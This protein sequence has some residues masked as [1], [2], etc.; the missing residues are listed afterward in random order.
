LPYVTP[1]APTEIGWFRFRGSDQGSW[2]LPLLPRPH[3]AKTRFALLLAKT[4][5]ALP[6]QTFS[7]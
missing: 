4:S 3:F 2:R 6:G 7:T 1:V 5:F